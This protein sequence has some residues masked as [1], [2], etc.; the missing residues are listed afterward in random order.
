MVWGIDGLMNG[1]WNANAGIKA[2]DFAGGTVVHMTSGL[3]GA[4]SLPDPR[5]THRLRQ[6]KH[7]SAQHG[8]CA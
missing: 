5:Q 7:G 6:G 2:I 8:A 4:D 3:V 1:V